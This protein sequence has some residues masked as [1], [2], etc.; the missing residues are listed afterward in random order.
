[1]TRIAGSLITIAISIKRGR[2]V[3]PHTLNRQA[4]SFPLATRNP[5]QDSSSNLYVCTVPQ[6]KHVQHALRSGDLL[7]LRH[8]AGQAEYRGVVQ[9]LPYGQR[10]KVPVIV[11]PYESDVGS[12]NSIGRA[13][14]EENVPSAAETG[15]ESRLHFAARNELE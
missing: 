5:L 12:S 10:G 14:G 1:M 11:L 13:V 6:P 3:A 4:Q 2:C 15:Q 7:F 8:G 9:R